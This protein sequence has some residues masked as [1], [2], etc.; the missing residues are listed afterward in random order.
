MVD[1]GTPVRLLSR[2]EQ[3]DQQARLAIFH[4]GQVG[5]QG[6]VVLGHKVAEVLRDGVVLGEQIGGPFEQSLEDGAQPVA[7]GGADG[8][9]GE[10][11]CGAPLGVK[12][13][14]FAGEVGR[15][16]DEALWEHFTKDRQAYKRA[17]DFDELE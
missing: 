17:R 1:G 11:A 15:V 13:S 8:V 14:K 16:F 12:F 10:G 3:A 6:L 7:L 2:R 5:A 9:R 4:Q